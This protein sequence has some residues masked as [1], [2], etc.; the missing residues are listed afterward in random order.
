MKQRASAKILC[1]GVLILIQMGFSALCL[2]EEEKKAA[3]L[4]NPPVAKF[5]GKILYMEDLLE[6]ARIRGGYRQRGLSDERIREMKRE[7]LQDFVK[8]YLLNEKLAE[9]AEK[10]GMATDE[11]I[12]DELNFV[13]QQIFANLIYKQEVMDKIPSPSQEEVLKYYE[14]NKTQYFRQP[15]SFKMRHIFLTTYKEYVS[16]EGDTL[17]G[18]AEKLAGDKKMVEFIL[19]NDDTKESRYVKPEERADNLFL[20]LQ[21]GEK[22]LV[23]KTELEKK[24]ILIKV[25]Q[26]H[27][28]LNKG[29][30]F[31]LIAKKMSDSGPNSGEILG[32]I[33]PE[34]DKKPM[35]PE[36]IETV[37]KTPA[38]GISD[39]IQTK[40]GYNII[41]VEEKTEESHVP[42]ENVQKSIEGRLSGERRAERARGFLY[43]IATK[44]PGV[45]LHQ[46]LLTAANPSTD[47]VI[48]SLGDNITFTVAD[49]LG[50]PE[51]VRNE[52]KTVKDKAGLVLESKK[53]LLPLLARYAESRG[54]EKIQEFQNEYKQRKIS[55][56]S[57][58]YIRKMTSEL[59]KPNEAQLQ[60]FYQQNKARYTDT[61]KFDLSV[62]GLKIKDPGQELPSGEEEKKIADL[63]KKLEELRKNIKTKEDF[64]KMAEE[65]SEDPTRERKGYVGPVPAKYR[66]GF[67]G[68]LEKM[69]AGDLSEPFV[70]ANFIYL[71]RVNDVTPEKLREFKECK[72][73]VERDFDSDNR[74]DF[75]EKKKE[76]ILKAGG[77]EFLGKETKE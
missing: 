67:D 6:G 66:N 43:D 70:F 51:K 13:R 47:S 52:Q 46:E 19:K 69:K 23:P 2:G 29:A 63:K 73:A 56:L 34:K 25:K 49:Y 77:F 20:P 33:T 1:L 65:I 26:I 3:P 31:A 72:G 55:S 75:Q 17:E 76:E 7:E 54:M 36:I 24:E 27:E 28:D 45:V 30:D 21:P 37:K 18:I 4:D 42:F 41:K 38:G 48:L 5:E 32:P 57:D 71:I 35:L 15:F 68:R 53:I 11:K 50:I 16:R 22:L 39:I 44:T 62:I 9:L 12:K 60:E 61:E 40:H 8:D 74:R 14:D 58:K 64:E 10:D 59:L